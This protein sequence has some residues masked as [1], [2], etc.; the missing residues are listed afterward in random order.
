MKYNV[1]IL[2]QFNYSTFISICSLT[3]VVLQNN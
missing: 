2:V 3:K 1:V